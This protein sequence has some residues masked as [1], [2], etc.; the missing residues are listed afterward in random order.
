MYDRSQQLKYVTP[1]YEGCDNERTNIQGK[2][3]LSLYSYHVPYHAMAMIAAFCLL[4][5]FAASLSP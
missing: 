3:R 5:L 2:K 1:T 4:N